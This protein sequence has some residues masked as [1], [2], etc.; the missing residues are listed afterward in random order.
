[1]AHAIKTKY[2]RPGENYLNEII[3]GVSQK[4]MDGDFLVLSE[5]A[6]AVALGRIVDESRVSPGL[7]AKII[8]KIWMPIVW[9]YILGP[10]CHL[11]PKLIRQLRNYPKDAGS[12]HKQVVLQHAGLM[13]ALMFGS[14]G[15]IDG[16]NLP[17]TYTSLPLE[18]AQRIAEEIRRAIYDVLGKNVYVMITD[19]DKTYSF[20]NFHFTPRPKPIKGIHSLG[21][22]I[23]YL[24]GRIL[25][26]KRRATPLAVAGC[27]L[28]TE[29]ALRIAEFANRVRGY[30]AGRTVWEMAERFGVSLTEVSWEML[31]MVEH[32]P[33]VIVRKIHKH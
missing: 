5:K 9:G 18:N 21:G 1:M 3:K 19:T 28:P 26:L 31:E 30:G 24:A 12:R 22:L 2:W 27:S 6:I 15:G 7:N 23:A 29:E 17:Y 20:R 11:K 25:R 4:V 14:E 10:L 8:A 33:I 32:K 16:S 13:H